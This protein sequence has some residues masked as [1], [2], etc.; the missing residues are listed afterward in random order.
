MVGYG[1]AIA[2]LR[3]AQMRKYLIFFALVGV[4]TP[5]LFNSP[6]FAFPNTPMVHP[7]GEVVKVVCA[8]GGKNC[9]PKDAGHTKIG[10]QLDTEKKSNPGGDQECKGGGT[11]GP[12]IAGA[13]AHKGAVGTQIQRSNS[14]R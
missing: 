2:N 7:S 6:A 14:R 8:E 9:L 12:G 11:C 13:A 4:V 10:N 3:E 1:A 5:W